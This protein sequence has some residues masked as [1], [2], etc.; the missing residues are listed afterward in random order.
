MSLVFQVSSGTVWFSDTY[1]DE[2]K[3]NSIDAKNTTLLRKPSCEKHQRWEAE[4]IHCCFSNRLVHFP[5]KS[6]NCSN[7]G[8]MCGFSCECIYDQLAVP[9]PRFIWTF[10]CV[11]YMLTRRCYPQSF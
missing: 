10:S 9:C 4:S 8:V 1:K 5:F 6:L 2:T 3:E 7:P 11:Q